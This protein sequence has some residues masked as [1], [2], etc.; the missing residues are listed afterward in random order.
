MLTILQK[1]SLLRTVFQLKFDIF[2]FVVY[3]KFSKLIF[4]SKLKHILINSVYLYRSDIFNAITS[5]NGSLF[6]CCNASEWMETRQKIWNHLDGL[7]SYIHYVRKHVR[8]KCVRTA[9]STC[10]CYIRW[11][12]I[13]GIKFEPKC[14]TIL[15][16]WHRYTKLSFQKILRC[17]VWWVYTWTFYFKLE[18]KS[19]CRIFWDNMLSSINEKNKKQ[20]CWMLYTYDVINVIIAV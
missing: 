11:L 7:V 8:T 15:S 19:S 1:K 4:L 12:V 13:F 3:E 6:G 2:V 18:K 20:K 9:K 16:V 17:Q 10:M 5:L 14:S